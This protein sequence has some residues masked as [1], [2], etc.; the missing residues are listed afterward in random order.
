MASSSY[1]MD[2][3]RHVEINKKKN[4]NSDIINKDD[5]D[6]EGDNDSFYNEKNSNSSENEDS[7]SGESNDRDS[8]TESDSDVDNDDDSHQKSDDSERSN[9]ESKQ[10]KIND[11]NK[12]S[13]KQTTST[14]SVNFDSLL[15]AVIEINDKI[16]D[17]ERQLKKL[18]ENSSKSKHKCSRSVSRP[19]TAVL[20]YRDESEYSTSFDGNDSDIES[21]PSIISRASS[22]KRQ[23]QTNLRS[24]QSSGLSPASRMNMSFSNEK[25]KSIDAE[26]QRLLKNLL[27][28]K[29]NQN[30]PAAM[31]KK[32]QPRVKSASSINRNKRQQ[33]IERENLRLLHR[34]QSVKPSN[35][36]TRNT[37]LSDHS[38]QEQYSGRIGRGS[39]PS[40]AVSTSTKHFSG[41]S[42]PSSS[43]SS[44]QYFDDTASVLSAS[45]TRSRRDARNNLTRENL[46]RQ[47][48][49]NDRW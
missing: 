27:H 23:Y 36:L 1:L 6:D 26:N 39:R 33:E 37:L 4:I 16:E 5:S 13:V 17:K 3:I 10:I 14:K 18:G 31:R 21:A 47:R 48:N 15:K 19:R 2:G 12:D 40:S 35:A 49:W 44:S 43:Y 41:R 29:S 28:T 45:S 22:S 34:L 30:L 11:N 9:Q 24:Q 46:E 20:Q 7:S 42:R 32:P 38:K 25:V 8:H